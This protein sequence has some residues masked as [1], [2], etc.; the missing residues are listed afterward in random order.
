M[1]DHLLLHPWQRFT[2]IKQTYIIF[3]SISSSDIYVGPT[4]SKLHTHTA[5]PPP[6][7]HHTHVAHY[8]FTNP[9][10]YPRSRPQ[11][12]TLHQSST[13]HSLINVHHLSPI[14]LTTHQSSHHLRPMHPL[15]TCNCSPIARQLLP[16]CSATTHRNE[17][18]LGSCSTLRTITTDH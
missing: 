14:I 3:S 6:P 16:M 12:I 13:H 17:I 11:P 4:L 9:Q 8:T 10:L 15:I 7:H 2:K 18:Q 1:P 5:V